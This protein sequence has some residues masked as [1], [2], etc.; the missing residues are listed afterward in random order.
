M[1]EGITGKKSGY[2]ETKQDLRTFAALPRERDIGPL[3][4]INDLWERGIV[5]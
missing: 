3:G 2:P 5:P 4:R 1:C